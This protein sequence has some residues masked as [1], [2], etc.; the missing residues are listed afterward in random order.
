MSIVRHMSEMETLCAQQAER[1]SALEAD[2]AAFVHLVRRAAKEWQ[3]LASGRISVADAREAMDPLVGFIGKA[4][5]G[6]AILASMREKD[7]TIKV[8][9]EALDAVLLDDDAGGTLAP[10]TAQ[11]IRTA[12]RL[13]KRI[14]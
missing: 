10:E 13:A 2:N 6:A 3:R 12:L 7:E 4:H 11:T 8:L 1:V 14:Q 5:P 9:A